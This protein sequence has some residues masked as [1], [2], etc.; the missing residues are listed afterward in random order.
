MAERRF[1]LQLTLEFEPISNEGGNSIDP[2]RAE[3][4][5]VGGRKLSKSSI[6]ADFSVRPV[7]HLN[8]GAT[9]EAETV[10]QDVSEFALGQSGEN[11]NLDH[12]QNR[13]AFS[14]FSAPAASYGSD[15]FPPQS[16]DHAPEDK[17]IAQVERYLDM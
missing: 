11:I 7:G 9:L 1:R 14:R 2:S 8:V 12:L 5:S 4:P 17:G 16:L 15:L 6:G 10:V 3:I 13:S